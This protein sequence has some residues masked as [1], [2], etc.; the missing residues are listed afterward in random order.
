V[1]LSWWV[2]VCLGCLGGWGVLYGRGWA[3]WGVGS[4]FVFVLVPCLSPVFCGVDLVCARAGC[5]WRSGGGGF[6]VGCFFRLCGGRS[7]GPGGGCWGVRASGGLFLG[8]RRM[9]EWG[10]RWGW[11][12]LNGCS[13]WACGWGWVR[14]S[15][16][17]GLRGGAGCLLRGGVVASTLF[18]VWV[19]IPVDGLGFIGLLVV[20]GWFWHGGLFGGL[21]VFLLVLLC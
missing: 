9:F 8:C 5:D 20:Q 21:L 11:V 1:F 14:F 19:V 6:R 7:G 18:A 12:A 2:G 3:G 4:F 13:L 10:W 15:D 16:L 17:F